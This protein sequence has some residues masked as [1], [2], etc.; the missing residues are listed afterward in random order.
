MAFSVAWVLLAAAVTFIAMIRRPGVSQDQGEV[1]V[2]QSGKAVTI[3]AV[4]YSLA[5]LAGFLYISWQHGLEL[6]K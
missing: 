6:L 3:V 5:L 2:R 1:R 4:I